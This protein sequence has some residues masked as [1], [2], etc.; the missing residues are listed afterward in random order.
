MAIIVS[1]FGGGKKPATTTP[2]PPKESNATRKARETLEL[3]KSADSAIARV[4]ATP[5]ERM[6]ASEKQ[7]VISEIERLAKTGASEG[8]MPTKGVAKAIWRGAKAVGSAVVAPFTPQN[9]PVSK[10]I[11]ETYKFTQRPGQSLIKELTDIR[12]AKGEDPF[13]VRDIGL[14]PGLTGPARL[15]DIAYYNTIGDR[16]LDPKLKAEL[17]AQAAESGEQYKGSVT[18]FLKQIADPEFQYKKTA[19]A[20]AVA[21]TNPMLGFASELGTEIISDPL[22]YVTGVGNVKYVGRAGKLSLAQR[23]STKQMIA[24]YPQLADKFND[25]VRYGQHA[26]I[27]G[28]RDILK[29]E[30]IETGVRV[31]G[32]VVKGTERVSAPVGRAMA[33]TW[34]KM[35]DIATGIRSAEGALSPMSRKFIMDVGRRTKG[36]YRVAEP[37][38]LRDVANWSARQFAKGV[39]PTQA[40]RF[41]GQIRETIASAREQGF[42]DDL[43]DLVER[44]NPYTNRAA[45]EAL[46]Q[47][48]RDLVQS[49]VDWQDA[50]YRETESVYKKFGTDYGTIVP[51]FSWVQN[52]VFHKMTKDAAEWV[53][54]NTGKGGRYDKFFLTGQLDAADISDMS[55]PLRYRKYR[56]PQVLEDGTVKYEEF[57]GEQ[58]REGTIKE[59][60]EIFKRQTGTE[61]DFFETDIGTIAESYAFSMAKMR[62]REAYVRRL[63]DYG[64]TASVK[65]L[66]NTIPDPV[67]RAAAAKELDEITAIRNGLRASM[68]RNMNNLK[69]V[70]RRGV[71]DA[72]EIVSG[73]LRLRKSNKRATEEALKRLG[74]LEENLVSLR[75]QA[76]ELGADKRGEFDVVQA[77]LLTNIQ[78]LRRALESGT[79]ELDEVRVGLQTIYQ[80]MYPNKTNIPDDIDVL[81]DRIMAV[82]GIPAS[83]EARA[84]NAQMRELRTQLDTLVPNS[85]EYNQLSAEIDRLKDLDN[86]FRVMAEYRAAQ[87]YAPDNGFLYIT[88]REM[89]ETDDMQIPNKLLRT[90]TTGF[91]DP[92]D[93][94]AVRVFGADELIDTRTSGGVARTFGIYDFGDG[95][96]DQLRMAGIDPTP[97]ETALDAVR[98]GLPIDPELEQAYPE[99]ADL[100][101]LLLGNQGRE[102]MPYGDPQ[103]IKA[104][105]E[106]IVD[107][108]TGLLMKVG[109]DNADLVGRNVVDG[110]LG[111]VADLGIETNSA[112]GILLPAQLFDDSAELDDVVVLL[113]P[114][115][116]L[117][118]TDSVTGSVQDASSPLIKAI[119]RS[120]EEAAANAARAKLNELAARKAEIDDTGTA[121]REQLVKLNRRKAGLKGAAT[122]RKNAAAVA[123]ERAGQARN[124]PREIVVDGKPTNM[125]LAQI[126][127]RLESLTA[128]EQRLRARM[129]ATLRREQAALKADGLTL[130]GTEAKMAAN[131]DRL[132][133]LADEALALHSWDIGTGMMVRDE[134]AAGIDLIASM[135]PAGTG[136]EATRNWLAGVQRGMDA[137]TVIDNPSL[138][139]SYERLHQL[140]AYDEWNLS[141]AEEAVTT[142]AT[143]LEDIDAGRLGAILDTIDKRTL[144]GWE[145]IEGLGVQIPKE[146]LDV[147][148]PNLAKILARQ[149]RAKVLSGLDYLNQVFK[150]YALATPGFV[151]RNLY[152]A[153]FMN[154]VAGVD[155]Q[156]MLDGWKAAR[157]YNKYGADKWLDKL[158]VTGLK[159]Q[160]YEQAMLAVEAT[161]R[162][163]FFA[164][165]AEPVVGGTK[166][167]KVANAILNNPWT[168]LVRGSNTRVEDAVRF[169]LALK[170][171]Q[172]GDD[173]VGAA[174]Q[175]TR[176]H[177]DYTDLSR[178]DSAML[179][180]LPFW[181][182][183]TR[184][185]PNQLANQWMRPQ[186]Y[187]FWENVQDSLPA[188]DN[189]LY[190]KWMKEYEPLGLTRFGLSPTILLRPD[191]PHQR[192]VKTIEDLASARVIG[193]AYPTYKLPVELLAADKNISLDQPF[194]DT[195]REAKGIDLALATVLN[196]LGAEGLAPKV[197]DESGREV[198]M[199][200]EKPSYALGNIVPLIATLQRLAGGEFGG[201]ESYSDR[202]AS[203]IAS[204]LGVPVDFVTDKMQGSE[205][206]GRQY[207]I[208]DYMGELQKAG[209][210]ESKEVTQKRSSEAKKVQEEA[211]KRAKN[212]LLTD[213][214][215]LLL[216]TEK[217]LG[218]N[219]QQYKDLK[220]RIKDLKSPSAYQKRVDEENII[221]LYGKGSLEHRRFLEERNLVTGG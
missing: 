158:G 48:Q 25:I 27:E 24:K 130:R 75:S 71:K 49:Y 53:A 15:L 182:W 30:G 73:N 117:R 128:S 40:N 28:F 46:P 140:V 188:D 19:T 210:L 212:Q 206:I 213:L 176:Y 115:V 134:I 3:S 17:V 109:V 72:E 172:Q 41:I 191:L 184:N 50:V 166:R 195:P 92:K 99:V 159:R 125:T 112:R 88:G 168:K 149:N 89:A 113:A 190:P 37:T 187:S 150:T 20:K 108:T 181:I 131:T 36:A 78:N 95:L 156:T 189:V 79:A 84:I 81:A 64:D 106:E 178:V 51:D 66:N 155:P 138:R 63:M 35:M 201:K 204:F 136:G 154:G 126:D 167:E 31:L 13:Q 39:T 196:K 153:L 186:V 29:S 18:D 101:K 83:R 151:I 43:S 121:I 127:K 122:K 199:I 146:V 14:V 218:K 96:L 197:R 163:G 77:A 164:D 21:K 102:I 160:Q 221:A 120:D 139:A 8:Y 135:P 100:V 62:G 129:E 56:A 162:R 208:G 179:S 142:A 1:P 119:M 87:D 143:K 105:Y 145:A 45:F 57:M 61:I 69:D 59:L 70:I 214:S 148:R 219:S 42:A 217:K 209:L 55:A 58:V 85:D 91:P 11:W 65:L 171:I 60:N 34:E 82:K 124:L 123:K 110:G 12:I 203:S 173:Y 26:P 194:R 10:A 52:Y 67:I 33:G 141:L 175:V 23:L 4:R 6:S 44:A 114:R 74:K 54:Q 170:A 22:T 165:L 76:E 68:G 47:P 216:E 90:S 220:Q 183:T 177:F 9:N 157:Y 118:A 104:V 86:G 107:A 198:Q 185:I 192:L 133:V 211:A 38:A 144:E 98:V 116:S 200:T 215:T 32:Q 161:G 147:W 80:G 169:P 202:Q 2:Q 174:Q 93:V 111:F 7:F 205:A 16:K 180:V 94:V 97:L 137:S 152:S 193:Q 103:L 5:N 132:R 207:N